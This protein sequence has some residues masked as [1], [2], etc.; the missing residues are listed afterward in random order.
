MGRSLG[1]LF[2]RITGD[3]SQ[4]DKSV[5]D[6]RTEAQKL[7]KVATKSFGSIKLSSIAMGVATSAVFIKT[8]GF[9]KDSAIAAINAQETF[10]KFDAVFSQMGSAAES[11]AMQFKDSFDLAEVTAKKM[12]ADTGNILTGFGATQ[13]QAL[14]LSVAVNSLASDLASFTNYTGGAEGASQALTRAMLGERE[15]LK[16]LGIVIREEDINIKLAA[17]GQKDLTGNALNLAKA[18][19]T[20]EIAM[21]QGKN[22]IGDYA[23]THDSAAN[24]LK[25]AKEATTELQVQI[26]TALSPSVSLLGSLWGTVAAKLAEVIA[27]SNRLREAEAVAG[28]E[29]DTTAAK[30]ERLIEQRKQLEANVSLEKIYDAEGKQIRTRA[31]EDAEKAL[32]AN[33]DQIKGLQL[34]LQYE[35]QAA[36]QQADAQ[37]KIATWNESNVKADE[38]EL[39]RA[40]TIADEK[41]AIN[42][43]YLA[44]AEELNWKVR[45]GILTEIEERDAL[46]VATENQIQALYDLY[47]QTGDQSILT[48]EAMQNA[49]VRVGKLEKAT[50][51]AT[52]Q[53]SVNFQEV[54][55]RGVRS[56]LSG[57]EDVG[58][59]LVNGGD[60]W[61]SFAKAALNSIAS[62]LEAM[63][64]Q[65]AAQAAWSIANAWNT[66]GVSLSGAGPAAAGAA[67]AY[68]AAGAIRAVAANFENGGIVEPTSSGAIVRVAENG[69]GEVLF[70]TG[71]SGQAFIDQMGNAIAQR[72]SVPVVLEIDG[73]RLAAVVVRPI[74]NGRVRLNV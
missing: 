24:T 4:F 68:A 47:V 48:S 23:R 54:T 69:S 73:E 30:I 22:A 45:E 32:K 29:E 35:K 6:T 56:L 10:S 27:Q 33:E 2:W 55:D 51:D 31:L 74:N 66:V 61:D 39:A 41:K 34:R 1:D 20:L 3:T 38:E 43:E 50:E 60:L 21:E 40:K 49:I 19:A 65:L 58:A 59:T 42:D 70:N 13:S 36:D 28:T 64:A 17:K 25:R 46:K 16:L 37:N 7:D 67:A 26:G 63:A 44:Q 57:M 71:E 8:I 11:A 53:M 14:D 12:I 15:S 72:L 52:D 18:Q 9:L 5:K 62:I